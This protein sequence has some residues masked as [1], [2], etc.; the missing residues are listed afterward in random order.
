MNFFLIWF[1]A[2]WFLGVRYCEPHK[3]CTFSQGSFLDTRWTQNFLLNWPKP[4]SLGPTSIG[5]IFWLY[6]CIYY[7]HLIPSKKSNMVHLDGV[8]HEGAPPN[9]LNSLV[10]TG[11]RWFD[12]FWWACAPFQWHHLPKINWT[13]VKW[14]STILNACRIM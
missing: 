6:I 14:V 4:L 5:N 13:L 7:L 8:I 1:L 10:R 12:L 2:H 11:A 9:L 3:V